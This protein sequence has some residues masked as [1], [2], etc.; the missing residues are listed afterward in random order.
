[1]EGSCH[2][3]L[4]LFQLAAEQVVSGLPNLLLLNRTPVIGSDYGEKCNSLGR[5]SEV[6]GRGWERKNRIQGGGNRLYGLGVKGSGLLVEFVFHAWVLGHSYPNIV[7]HSDVE[8]CW[9]PFDHCQQLVVQC[10][11]LEDVL[12]VLRLAG[13]IVSYEDT[14]KWSNKNLHNSE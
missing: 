14:D 8:H 11:G 5:S 3:L 6:H 10:I 4:V 1:M 7:E 12:L 13:R 2:Q 9:P